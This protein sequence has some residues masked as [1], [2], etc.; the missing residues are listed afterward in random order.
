MKFSWRI[1]EGG[2]NMAEKGLNV[3]EDGLTMLQRVAIWFE[4]GL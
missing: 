4:A 2:L 3:T 1:N